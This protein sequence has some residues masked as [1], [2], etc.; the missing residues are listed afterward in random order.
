[1]VSS[2]GRENMAA[3]YWRRQKC[4]DSTWLSCHTPSVSSN[5][6]LASVPTFDADRTLAFVGLGTLFRKSVQV[7]FFSVDPLQGQ[8]TTFKEGA[9]PADEVLNAV[10]A[11]DLSTGAHYVRENLTG[12]SVLCR[13]IEG[14]TR[15]LVAYMKDPYSTFETERKGEFIEYELD[16][17]EGIVTPTFLTFFPNSVV[18][19]F[20]GSIE[21]PGSSKVASWLSLFSGHKMYFAPL[22]RADYASRLSGDA[23]EYFR[24]ELAT[25]RNRI[26]RIR[27]A[28]KG[29]A[30]ALEAASRVGT[31]SKVGVQLGAATHSERAAW[32][33][34]VRP[35]IDDIAEVIP[36]FDRAVVKVSHDRDVNLRQAYVSTKSTIEI[37]SRRKPRPADAARALTQAYV[38]EEQAIVVALKEW[39]ARRSGGHD[40][41]EPTS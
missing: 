27:S 16:D 30:D 19:L 10:A 33:G 20:R 4:S 22:P 15:V 6:C 36:E 38:Q 25:R 39:R 1:M 24:L 14:P 8:D 11:L 23:G 31:S 32:W 34:H 18:G 7:H 26:P 40:D 17:G 2:D 28:H 41:A 29:V 37:D 9:F 3:S 13:V 12:K 5:V 21:S 35:I